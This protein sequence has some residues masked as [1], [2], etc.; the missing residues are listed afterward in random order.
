MA[1]NLFQLGDFTLHSGKRSNFKIECDALT[2]ED[3]DTI[4]DWIIDRYR[5]SEVYGVPKGGTKLA[6]RLQAHTKDNS[7]LLIVD[8]VFST[9]TSMDAAKAKFGRLDTLGVV[10]FARGK[11]PSWIQPIFQ[12][13]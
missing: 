1:S 11:C 3:W 6:E 4:A 8:D 13:W 10:V 2:D 12:M 9:G 7:C 5:F